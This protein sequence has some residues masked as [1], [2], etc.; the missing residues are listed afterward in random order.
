MGAKREEE[1]GLKIMRKRVNGLKLRMEGG[2]GLQF[3]R[4]EIKKG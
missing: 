2:Y 4:K 3:K 1:N